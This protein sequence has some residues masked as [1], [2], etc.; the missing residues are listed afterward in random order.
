MKD[1]S[2]PGKVAASMKFLQT[3]MYILVSR[4]Y[5]TLYKTWSI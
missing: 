5:I 1:V 4:K 3:E 2:D